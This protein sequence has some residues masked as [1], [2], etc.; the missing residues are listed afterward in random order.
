MKSLHSELWNQVIVTLI[1]VMQGRILIL[2]SKV[3]LY[4]V[5]SMVYFFAEFEI[6]V[7]SVCNAMHST[8]LT[9][10]CHQPEV[11]DVL[12]HKEMEVYDL[13]CAVCC[14]GIIS[15][16][17]GSKWQGCSRASP[18][19]WRYKTIIAYPVVIRTEYHHSNT[20]KNEIFCSVLCLL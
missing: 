11:T 7:Q 2:S 5:V 15:A 8:R 20:G 14:R 9:H 3:W 12:P 10:C 17:K 13:T 4:S 6:S 18:H 1:T 19:Q 16:Y